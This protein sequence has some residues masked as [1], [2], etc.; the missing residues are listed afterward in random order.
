MGKMEAVTA[1]TGSIEGR[2]MLRVMVVVPVKLVEG[3]RE[4]VEVKL[5]AE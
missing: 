4:A 2:G 1:S 3:E 5:L